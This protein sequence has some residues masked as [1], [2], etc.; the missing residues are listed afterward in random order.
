MYR[1]GVTCVDCHDPHAARLEAEGNALCLRCHQ[2]DLAT[3]DHTHH[4]PASV[5]SLCVSCHMPQTLYMVRDP[6]RDHSFS[7]PDPDATLALEIPNACTRCHAQQGARWAADHAARWY[8]TPGRRAE[9]RGTAQA[10]HD[11]RLRLDTSLPSLERILAGDLDPVRRASAGHLLG[12]FGARPEV[13]EALLAAARDPEPLVR[14]EAASAL[15]GLGQEA[16]ASAALRLLAA[17]PVRLVRVRA[18]W[19]LRSVDLSTLPPDDARHLAAALAEWEASAR[20]I[21]DTPEAEHNLGVFYTDRRDVPR[22][23]AAYRQAL[24][25]WPAA[26]RSR[27]NLALLLARER[28]YPEAERELTEVRRRE[29]SFAPAAFSLGLLRGQQGDWPRAIEALEACV[30]ENASYPRAL[31]N[32]GLV[33]AKL[34]R[35]AAALEVLERAARLP[36]SHRDASLT[37]A[38][39]HRQMGNQIEAERWAAEA[40]K[41]PVR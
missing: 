34:D 38:S 19:E 7:L 26:S 36:D 4:P 6:R 41:T 33:Y 24:T 22:A 32:L 11:G 21:A 2:A 9:R 31:Y 18:A 25:I 12:G 15:G 39:I 3:A 14:A 37:L 13:G 20:I 10:I 8:G 27:Y 28:R 35:R 23:I 16:R 17:D 1:A 29:P 30:S 40:D 5:G